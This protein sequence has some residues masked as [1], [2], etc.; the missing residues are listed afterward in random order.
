MPGLTRQPDKTRPRDTFQMLVLGPVEQLT[1]ALMRG[2]PFSEQALRE[3]EH[4]RNRLAAFD[5]AL[6]TRIDAEE[7]DSEVIE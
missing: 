2:D 5:S 7:K 6:Q 3:M 4:L 1:T